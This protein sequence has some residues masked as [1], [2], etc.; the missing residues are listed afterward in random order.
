MCTWWADS[1][2]KYNLF[3]SKKN[4]GIRNGSPSAWY[5]GQ[6]I[7][8][9]ALRNTLAGREWFSKLSIYACYSAKN[10]LISQPGTFRIKMRILGN[11]INNLGII[12]SPLIVSKSN[13]KIGHS[14]Q[15]LI[16]NHTPFI[17]CVGGFVGFCFK[18]PWRFQGVTFLKKRLYRMHKHWPNWNI[19]RHLE[20]SG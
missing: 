6:S 5:Q 17:I 13:L 2:L 4:C 9:A 12:V 14:L 7:H 3:S 11:E 15:S 18:L 20:T 16:S 19:Q 10:Y 1:T 8:F